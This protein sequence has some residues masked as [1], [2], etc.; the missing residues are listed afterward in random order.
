[1]R[2]LL[3]MLGLNERS[4]SGMGFLTHC[5]SSLLLLVLRLI[6]HIPPAVP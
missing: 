5:F 3:N 4:K 1:M 2:K 6:V